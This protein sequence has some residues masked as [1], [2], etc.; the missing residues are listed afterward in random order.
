MKT[1]VSDAAAAAA[2]LDALPEFGAALTAF[3]EEPSAA[4]RNAAAELKASVRYERKVA[5][6]TY[7][8]QLHVANAADHLQ[9]LP[10]DG[11]SIHCVMRGN[12]HAW[13][14]VPAL[15]RLAQSSGSQSSGSQAATIDYLGVATLGFNAQNATAA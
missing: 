9:R 1:G 2:P 6:R 4:A 13:D 8:H 10:D 12:Y 11:E 14:L 3:Y 15:L 5:K 7:E